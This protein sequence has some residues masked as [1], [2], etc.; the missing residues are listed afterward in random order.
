MDTKKQT[1][2]QELTE[3]VGNCS[4]SLDCDDVRTQMTS[5]TINGGLSNIS[6]SNVMNENMSIDN[7]MRGNVSNNMS[8][9]MSNNVGNEAINTNVMGDTRIIEPIRNNVMAR[10]NIMVEHVKN[11]NTMDNSRVSNNMINNN[12]TRNNMMDNNVRGNNMMNNSVMGNRTMNNNMMNNNMNNCNNK[13]CTNERN[14][15]S[16]K[17]KCNPSTVVESI[18]V[19]NYGCPCIEEMPLAM[20]YVPMQQFNQTYDSDK[21]LKIGT[22]FPELNMPFRGRRCGKQ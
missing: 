3:G 4:K 20:A 15:C 14:E 9:N 11:D 17:S 13:N 7:L 6:G 12:R 5:Q 19:N 22:I 21:A 1:M 18:S 16:N 8:N 10:E 2:P